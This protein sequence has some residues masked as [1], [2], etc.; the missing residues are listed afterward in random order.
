MRAGENLLKE[1]IKSKHLKEQ[2]FIILT[3]V[4]EGKCFYVAVH[5]SKELLFICFKDNVVTEMDTITKKIET[6]YLVEQEKMG[7]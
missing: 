3:K 4:V 6:L 7:A 1:F 2:D 5:K